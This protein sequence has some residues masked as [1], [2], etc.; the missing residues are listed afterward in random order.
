MKNSFDDY[1]PHAWI[2]RDRGWTDGAIKKYLGKP[3]YLTI[4]PN[5]NNGP[6]MKMYSMKRI[7]DAERKPDFQEWYEKH[8]ERRSQKIVN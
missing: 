8:Q 5:Y 2:K 7:A 4:N 1:I 6:K 3:D